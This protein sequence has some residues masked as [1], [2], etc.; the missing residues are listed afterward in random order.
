MV[1]RQKVQTKKQLEQ[2]KLRRRK[3]KEDTKAGSDEDEASGNYAYLPIELCGTHWLSPDHMQAIQYMP[4]LMYR[5]QVPANPRYLM[6]QVC[7]TGMPLTA[8]DPVNT[9]AALL[10][11]MPLAG[12]C[13]CTLL[14]CASADKLPDCIEWV[15]V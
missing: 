4:S 14:Q 12:A 10:L 15:I 6:L 1:L 9:Q 3:D 8:P 7:S 11:W 5:L 2:R 13:C